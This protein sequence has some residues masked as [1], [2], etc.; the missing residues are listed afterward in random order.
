MSEEPQKTF[1]LTEA[2][3]LRHDVEPLLLDA[4]ET[5]RRM[6]ELEENLQALAQ[7]IQRMGGVLVAIESAAALR[8]QHDQHGEA[9]EEVLK[10]IH[11]TGCVVK[12]LDAGLLDFPG[13]IN[14]QDIYYCWKVGEDR[15]RF[16]HTQD[17]GF[18]GRKP[19]DP[20]D[21]EYGST[22]H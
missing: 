4:M 13:R 18:A 20:R 15:I 22:I 19:I 6:A 10:K 5:R 3:R 16:Y 17:E 1:T 11:L 12:D 21:S 14:D 9:I 7:H 8:I 2:E